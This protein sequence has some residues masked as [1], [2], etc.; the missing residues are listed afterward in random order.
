MI[1][2]TAKGIFTKASLYVYPMNIPLYQV[3]A[4]TTQLF[5]GNPAAVCILEDW[6]TDELM[7]RI[8]A[9]NNLAET[10][11]VVKKDDVYELRWFTPMTEVAL[12]GHA[13]LAAAFVLFE[14]YEKE[15]SVINFKTVHSGMLQVTRKDNQSFTLNFPVDTIKE[16][17]LK[18]DYATAFGITPIKAFQGASDVMLIYKNQSQ[19]EQLSPNMSIISR[20]SS[21]GVICTA[22]GD[23]VEVVSRWFG[24]QVGVPEDPVTGSAHTTLALYW[25]EQ[26]SRSAFTAKQL[27]A[28]GGEIHCLLKENRVELT[29]GAVLYLKGIIFVVE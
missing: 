1:S 9:E 5:T 8:A 29:G 10:A 22:P 20:L 25:C 24:P 28:R 13:T 26:L 12:C 21:R 23:M 3:D 11:F 17:S 19:I 16:I 27:S 7:Q 4:F 18:E 14:A 15:A 2:L 6:I